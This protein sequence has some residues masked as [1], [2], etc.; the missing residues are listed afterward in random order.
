MTDGRRTIF[1]LYGLD[2]EILKTEYEAVGI[3]YVV[4]DGNTYRNY[5][6]YSFI[7]EKSYV[8]SPERS[9]NGSIGNLNSYAT[10]IT[11][12]FI[13]DFSVISIDDWR[14]IMQQH[15]DKNEYI[16]ECYDPIYD[17]KIKKKMYFATEEMPKL[18][19]LN[20]RRF[21]SD[22]DEWEDFIALV[23]VDSYKL[24]M[25]GTNSSLDYISVI[26]H[27]NP[28]SELGLPDQTIGEEDLYVGEEII[29][30]QVASSWYNETYGGKY[31][32]KCWNISPN[33]GDTGNY[34]K[35]T[36]YTINAELVL[37]AI[38]ESTATRKLYYSYGLSTPEIA[39]GQYVYSKEVAKDKPIGALPK[40]DTSPQ[41]KYGDKFYDNVYYNGGW[42]K[43]AIKAQNSVRVT[44]DTLYWLDTDTTIYCLYDTY[45]YRVTYHTN[46]I[47]IELDPIDVKYGEQVFQPKLYTD[48]YT[49]NGWYLDAGFTKTLSGAMPPFAIDL[50]A[51]WTKNEK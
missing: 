16:V 13:I 19:T 8:K 10:F 44:A 24:E 3:D 35:D 32:F 27:K 23:G 50:Y 34:L 17:K 30:G 18:R 5:G 47:D 1:E 39:N 7:W 6:A 21:S 42:Y 36:A 41:V 45:A 28:P 38:W 15:L 29:V 25:V 37:Y 33:G 40:I 20:R 31:Q 2:V 43:T 26:Y 9:G 12:H 48:G 51:K 46:N 4:I 22:K 11:P 49:F 14:K